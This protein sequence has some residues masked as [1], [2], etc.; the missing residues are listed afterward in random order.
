MEEQVGLLVPPVYSMG[1]VE[2]EVEEGLVQ[3]EAT[4]AM[5]AV[6]AQEAAAAEQPLGAGIL[7]QVAQ[8][9]KDL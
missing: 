1:Q 8:E 5:E 6:M 2:A 4:E 7:E 3:Q 9:P